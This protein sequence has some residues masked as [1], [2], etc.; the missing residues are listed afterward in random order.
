MKP[1]AI[2]V[3]I[4]AL[5]VMFAGFSVTEPRAVFWGFLLI[6]IMGVLTGV[7]LIHA[8]G[9][10]DHFRTDLQRVTSRLDEEAQANV[11]RNRI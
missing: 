6:G 8:A 7:G 4:A 5:L 2:V 1:A 9:A 10:I 11:K 3:I